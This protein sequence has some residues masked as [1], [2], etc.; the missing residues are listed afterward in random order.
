M[1][2]HFCVTVYILNEERKFLFIKHKKLRKWLPPGGHIELNETPDNAA[3]REVKE[4]TGLD[5]E[6]LGERFPRSSD[7]VR[8]YAIQTNVIKEGE[9]EHLDLIYFAKP[10]GNSNLA[11][12]ESETDGINWYSIPEILDNS[13][14]T[15]DNTKYWCQ[16]FSGQLLN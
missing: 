11:L 8:P 3:I 16:K 1:E 7:C 13:F 14:D 6:L 10:I 15:F 2:R 4:E 12:N 9:H 5:I